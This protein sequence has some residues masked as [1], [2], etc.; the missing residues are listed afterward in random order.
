MLFYHLPQW[1]ANAVGQCSKGI[2]AKVASLKVDICLLL[3]L[4]TFI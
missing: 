2:I 1:Y 3:M 4:T